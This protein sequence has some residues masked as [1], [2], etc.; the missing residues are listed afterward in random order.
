[1]C[2]RC[3]GRREASRSLSLSLTDS[4]APITSSSSQLPLLLLDDVSKHRADSIIS[5]HQKAMHL[6]RLRFEHSS[7]PPQ[8]ELLR[9]PRCLR[10]ATTTM[11]QRRFSW[12]KSST[13][14]E[15]NFRLLPNRRNNKDPCS[16]SV[17]LVLPLK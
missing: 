10:F 2:F 9:A 7:K 5:H 16:A 13:K 8:P 4:S 14:R 15:L 6:L 12:A 17:R 3:N 11:Y 1:M